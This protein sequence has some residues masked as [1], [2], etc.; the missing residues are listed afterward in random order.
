MRPVQPAPIR[1]SLIDI[2]RPPSGALERIPVAHDVLQNLR[3]CA[4]RR[5]SSLRGSAE[6]QITEE[7]LREAVR[8]E[9]T[10]RKL[11]SGDI[12]S[13]KTITDRYWHSGID[14]RRMEEII[15]EELARRAIAG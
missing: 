2:I 1:L 11:A 8:A 9:L 6:D 13:A 4:I 15:R 5:D 3:L 12:V 10:A 14:H 7:Q